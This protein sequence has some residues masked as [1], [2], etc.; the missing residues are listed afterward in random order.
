M[1]NVTPGKDAHTVERFAGDFM[2]HNGDPDR[3]RLVACDMGL[4]FAKGIRQWLPNAA[5]IIDRFLWSSTPT[6]PS[7]RCARRRARRTAC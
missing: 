2:D 1:I 6:G 3:V 5:K 7:T 4:G